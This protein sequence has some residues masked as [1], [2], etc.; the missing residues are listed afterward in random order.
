MNYLEQLSNIY[1]DAE[2]Y[3]IGNADPTVYSNLIW[4]T[5]PIPQATLDNQPYVP[6]Q[7]GDVINGLNTFQVT[8][9]S[10]G[11]FSN[12][13]IGMDTASTSDTCPYVIPWKSRLIGLNFVN[14]TSNANIDIQVFKADVGLGSTNTLLFEWLIRTARTGYKT[15]LP[16]ISCN[17]G[18]K[19]GIFLK[20]VDKYRPRNT[21]I[22]M[23]FQIDT[24]ATLSELTETFTGDM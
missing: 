6:I 19:I 17:A 15:N 4:I 13:W 2:A 11:K 7:K 23:F 18:D 9:Q 12:K 20:H 3:V 10:T 8:F 1:P 24:N 14:I 21:I 16:I 5:T 22:T